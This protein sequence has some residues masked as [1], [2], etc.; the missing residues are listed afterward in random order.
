MTSALRPATRPSSALCQA[1][2]RLQATGRGA[3][4]FGGGFCSTPILLHHPRARGFRKWQGSNR[5]SDPL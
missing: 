1:P 4:R 5:L 3:P 2:A